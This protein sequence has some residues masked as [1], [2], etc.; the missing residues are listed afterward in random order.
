MPLRRGRARGEAAKCLPVAVLH[1][2]ARDRIASLTLARLARPFSFFDAR[3]Q[4][5]AGK[6][7][8]GE[9]RTQLHLSNSA[10]VRGRC[11]VGQS[12]RGEPRG[13]SGQSPRCAPNLCVT[14]VIHKVAL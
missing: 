13:Y 11:A 6:G 10:Y 8:G 2:A 1:R 14:R 12:A 4:T 9:P 5:R 7:E 3:V